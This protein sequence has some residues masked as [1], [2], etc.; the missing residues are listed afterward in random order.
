MKHEISLILI[1]ARHV[2][3]TLGHHQM[4][5]LKLAH[6]TIYNLCFSMCVLIHLLDASSHFVPSQYKSTF[7]I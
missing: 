2:S 1:L 7:S 5:L 4:L 6:C 3:A